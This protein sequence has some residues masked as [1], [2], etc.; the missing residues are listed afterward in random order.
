[1][2][3]GRSTL[4]RHRKS[5]MPSSYWPRS[6]LSFS[7][8]SSSSAPAPRLFHTWYNII[9]TQRS[10]MARYLFEDNGSCSDD[11]SRDIHTVTRSIDLFHSSNSEVSKSLTYLFNRD[12]AS[13]RHSTPGLWFRNLD[14]TRTIDQYL[15]T[16]SFSACYRFISWHLWY[17]MR[18]SSRNIKGKAT[19][20]QSG[21]HTK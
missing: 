5:F 1:M 21:I 16:P 11:C 3:T 9:L 8:M 20:T 14:T 15:S 19:A 18:M 6:T 4:S 13:F 7:E 17:C 12:K 2:N 10:M